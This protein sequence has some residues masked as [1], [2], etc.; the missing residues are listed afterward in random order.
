MHKAP[1]SVSFRCFL[2]ASDQPVNT[3]KNTAKKDQIRDGSDPLLSRGRGIR[4]PMNGF[5]DRDTAI[6]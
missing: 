1:E 3:D 6:V 4:T 5:G 2:S